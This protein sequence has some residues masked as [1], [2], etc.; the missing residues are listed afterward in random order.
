MRTV[1]L[2]IHVP[3]TYHDRS[4][5]NKRGLYNALAQYGETVEIDFCAIAPDMLP[6]VIDDQ[7]MKFQP[8]LLWLQ[9]GAANAETAPM[10]ADWRRKHPDMA[11]VNWNGDYSPDILLSEPMLAFLRHVDLQLVANGGVLEGYKEAG[12]HAAFCAHAYEFPASELPDVPAYDVV[13]LANSYNEKRRAL[14]DMLRAL[15]YNVGVYGTGWPQAEGECNYDFAYGEALYR[16]AKIAIS[17][18]QFP[19]SP[20]YMSDRPFQVMGAGGAMLVQ[21]RVIDLNKLTGINVAQHHASFDF[22]SQLPDL[23]DFLLNAELDSA[24]ISTA[25][26]ARDFVLASHTWDNRVKLALDELARVMV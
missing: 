17:H 23:I 16:K 3:G 22:L 4:V 1:Y 5:A 7:L 8:D 10:V 18:N 21:E 25:T 11:V 15:P 20:G 24:R 26:C 19:D 6:Q 2:P 13:F 9:F 12:I 14:Y